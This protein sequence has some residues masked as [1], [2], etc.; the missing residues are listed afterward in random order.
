MPFPSLTRISWEAPWATLLHSSPRSRS[1]M[2]SVQRSASTT[3]AA[4]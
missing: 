3:F 2:K 4:S 1:R